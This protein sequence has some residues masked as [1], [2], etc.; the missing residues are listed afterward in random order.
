MKVVEDRFESNIEAEIK[1]RNEIT[2]ESEEKQKL[3]SNVSQADSETTDDN[4]SK[5]ILKSVGI[6]EA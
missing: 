6:S 3:L 4:L 5:D 1:N 2:E